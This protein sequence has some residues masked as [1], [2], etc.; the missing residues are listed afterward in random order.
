[1]AQR[2]I[3]VYDGE[4]PGAQSCNLVYTVKTENGRQ[5][6]AQVTEPTLTIYLPA[7]V[8][9]TAAV[10][11]CPGGGYAR[12]A[13]THEGYDVAERFSKAGVAAF[14][15]QYR[16]PNDEC[17]THKEIRP[18][19]DLQQAIVQVRAHAAEWQ[20]DT[21]KI[22][23]M[24]FSAGGHLAST[25]ITHFTEKLVNTNHSVRPDFGILIYPVIN[26]QFD[27]STHAGSRKNLLGEAPT[28]AMVK[29]YSNQL[30][31]TAATPPVF[32][33]HAADDGSVPAA[34]SIAFATAAIKQKIPVE[35][36]IYPKG[37]HG[38]GMVNPTTK[39]DW[40]E[41]CLNWMRSSGWLAVP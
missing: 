39:E 11:I 30:Q 4:I 10:I 7:A 26:M 37:G 12:L 15:L 18:L 40:F 16:L 32:L 19:Q 28:G 23:V 33:V 35:M 24:G 34:N 36:H 14:I 2:T 38:F 3:N 29:K 21:N 31:I 8:K 17:M 25:G 27:S 5:S 6:V 41:A 20:I 1:M 9:P 13:I 22:G